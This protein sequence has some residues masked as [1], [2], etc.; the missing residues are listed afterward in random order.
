M[1]EADLYPHIA[2]T[3]T[4]GYSAQQFK[5][6]FRSAALVGAVGPSF[7]WNILN[8]GR[9]LN[10]VRLQDARLQELLT[11]YQNTVLTAAQDVENGLV[12]FLRAQQR[13]QFQAASVADA[14][15]AVKIAL[16]NQWPAGL[17]DF[18]RVTQLEQ[19][20]VQVQDTL[21]QARGEI[22]LGLIQVYR[23][24][25]GGWQIRL[26]GCEPTALPLPAEPGKAPEILPP[27]TPQEAPAPPN[28]AKTE[29]PSVR[30]SEIRNSKTEAN[31][32]HEIPNSK[33]SIE[34]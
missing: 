15:E 5:D 31:S 25:G 4:I 20:L 24:L 30:K 29:V 10:N 17:I 27:P 16:K 6:L 3:G 34:D 12:T 13:A 9:I 23:A 33:P 14:E 26:T 18:T 22:A 7:Q 19:N 28:Q 32:K 11:V 8:Y 2:I 1:A 21:A